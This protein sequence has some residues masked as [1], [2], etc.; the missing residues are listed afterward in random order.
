MEKVLFIIMAG[1]RGERMRPLTDNLPKPLIRFGASARI[2]DFTLYNCL[3]SGAR[4]VLVLTQYLSGLLEDYIHEQWKPA[5]DYNGRRLKVLPG[6]DSWRSYFMGTADA[7]YQALAMWGKLPEHVVVLA[8]DHIY[9]MDYGPMIRFHQSHRAAAT[10]GAV[11]C[12]RSQAH[13]FG[14]IKAGEDGS[15][16]SFIEKPGSLKDILPPRKKPRASM[17]IYVFDTKPLLLYLES[18]QEENSHDFGRDVLPRM[19]AVN[20]IFSY[21]FIG[22]GG[23]MAYWRDVGDMNYYWKASMELLNGAGRQLSFENMPGLSRLPFS[24][25]NIVSEEGAGKKIMHSMV[26]GDARIGAAVVEESIIGPEVYIE[27]DAVVRRSV[28]LD[29]ALVTRSAPVENAVI[30]KSIYKM[31]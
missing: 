8:G 27:D 2:I 4:D 6:R 25:G 23:K 29:G 10:V 7:V 20:D 31:M 14:I 11:A 9:K 3:S 1:G 30:D 28:V 21:T 13:R 19:A 15:V 5:F 24:A 12:N 16:G 26:S 17:G 22:P 18:N